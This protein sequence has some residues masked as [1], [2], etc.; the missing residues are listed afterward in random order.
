M[1]LCSQDYAYLTRQLMDAADRHCGGKLLIIHEGGYSDQYTP[2]C[3][4]RIV[5]TL[6]GLE[7]GVDDSMVGG[8]PRTDLHEH[9]RAMIAQSAA[10]VERVPT[11]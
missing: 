9:E 6:S 2:Y 11:P 8:G 7:S 5:E 10:L 4:L 3:G 1:N